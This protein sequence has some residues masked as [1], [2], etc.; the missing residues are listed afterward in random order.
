MKKNDFALG[1]F[2][3]L[4]GL[5]IY[6]SAK[7]MPDSAG[8]FPKLSAMFLICLGILLIVSFLYALK[9]GKLTDNVKDTAN[10]ISYK[11]VIIILV[12][13]ISYIFV[14]EFLG[15][16]IPTL[17]L[18]IGVI[19]VTGYKNIKINFITSLSVTLMLYLIFRFLFQVNF[20]NGLFY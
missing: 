15:Y 14:F 19:F 12:F 2:S 9:K 10:K 11:K 16:I 5:A 6:I 1:I 4:F 8:T 7:R 13:F 20:P 18:M 3:V 17:F